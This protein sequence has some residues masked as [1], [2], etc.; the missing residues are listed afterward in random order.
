MKIALINPGMKVYNSAPPLNLLIL[1]GWLEKEGYEVKLIDR[2]RGC[3]LEKELN[4]FTP[5]VVGITGTTNVIEDAYGCAN[6]IK[7]KFGYYTVMGGSHVTAL[8]KEAIRFCDAVIV[9]EGDTKFVELIKSMEKGIFNGEPLKDL[10]TLPMPAYH[11]L[12]MEYYSNVRKREQMGLVSF[13]PPSA[14]IGFMITSRGC[15]HRCIYCHNST[16]KIQLRYKSPEKV[17]EEV[18]FLVDTYKLDSIVFLDDNFLL[19]HKRVKDICNLIKKENIDILFGINARV[20]SLNKNI[21]KTLYE[22]GCLQLAFGFESGNQRILDLLDKKTT[23]EQNKKAILLCDKTGIIV[24]G[25]FML[26]NPTETVKELEDTVKLIFEN[27]IDGGLGCSLTLPLPGTKLYQMCIERGLN[28]KSVRW[29]NFR[30]SNYPVTL[31]S[32]ENRFFFSV[33]NKLFNDLFTVFKDRTD[34]RID[35]LYRILRNKRK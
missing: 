25:N 3:N 23:V 29:S 19:K 31:H 10:N 26:G 13:L 17:I 14:K 1:G 2:L 24:S 20:D 34:S 6:F 28:I 16:R 5:D 9:G 7:E 8:P 22:A 4:E 30:Y 27:N 12:D 32:M 33:V 35:K 18:K 11:L 21:L 15:P